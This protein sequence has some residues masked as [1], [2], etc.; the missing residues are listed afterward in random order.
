MNPYVTG[1]SLEL[2]PE[3]LDPRSDLTL[4]HNNYAPIRPLLHALEWRLFPQD[5]TLYHAV[6]VLA[7]TVTAWLLVLLLAQAGLPLLSATFGGAVFL[8]HPA[9]VEAVAWISQLWSPV[10]LSLALGALLAQRRRPLLALPLFALAMLTKP[11]AICVLVVALLREWAW[12]TEPRGAARWI[13][14]AGWLVVA[15]AVGAA[16]LATFFASASAAR[17]ASHPDG[18]VLARTLV[19]SAGRYLVMA[20][21][22]FGVSAFQ[23]PRLA[24]S[25]LDPWWLLGLAAGTAVAVRALRALAQGREEGAWWAWAP[26]AFVPVSQIFPFLYPT[27]DRYLYFILP[28]LLGGALLAAL[29]LWPRVAP[30]RRPLVSRA[31][32]LGAVALV[33]G[34]GTWSRARAEIWVSEDRVLLDAAR[35][36]P[37]G[38]AAHLFRAR[39]AA[40]EGDVEAVVAAIDSCRARGWDYWNFLVQ[41]PD[42]E[43]VRSLPRFR[44]LIADIAG[45]SIASM[46]GRARRTQFEL[47]DQAEAH[48]VRGE[49]EDGVAA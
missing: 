20:V 39:R 47:R 17:E 36:H 19:A 15:A 31:L 3:L 35:H 18:L 13:T 46:E 14:V 32:A 7:H 30:E 24:L 28:G 12:R 6:N 26:A 29:V 10:A 34:F 22:G 41:H 16:E 9:N 27:A 2:V 43:P 33:L 45:E 11:L 4:F 23:E 38:V 48:R 21:T 25:W 5:S 8:V 40:R 44:A 37:E 49:Y 42:F 1:F